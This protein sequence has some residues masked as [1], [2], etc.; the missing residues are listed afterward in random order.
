MTTWTVS[1]AAQLQSALNGA[2]GG[3]TIVLQDGNYGT[4]NLTQ[5]FNDYVTIQAAS[6]LG[7]IFNDLDITG[8]SY[9][10]LDGIKVNARPDIYDNANHLAFLNCA[11]LGVMMVQGGAHDVDL[12]G[13]DFHGEVLMAGYAPSSVYN[14]NVVGNVLHDTD[15]DMMN[16]TGDSYNIL[17]ENNS[18]LDMIAPDPAEHPDFIQMLQDFGSGKT[19]HDVVI[20]GNF[21]FDDPTTGVIG[22]EGIFISDAGPSGYKNILVEQ[23]I[24]APVLTNAITIQSGTENVVIQDNTVTYG[25]IWVVN[26]QGYGNA[27]TTVRDN[28]APYVVNDGG[29]AVVTHNYAYDPTPTKTLFPAYVNGSDWHQFVPAAGSAIDFGNGYGA[30]ARLEEL[31][32]GTTTSPGN[33][34]PHGTNDTVN[35]NEDTAAYHQRLD[36][37]RERHRRERRHAVDHGRWK[38]AARHCDPERQRF[39]HVYADRELQRPGHLHLHGLA[40]AKAAPA[41]PPLR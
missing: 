22:A 5:S 19:P 23:N 1:S 17:V 30:D 28:V 3:D 10:K 33:A 36:P 26:N 20:R 25:R 18:F 24:I 29:G 31:L 41:R 34:S 6:P 14:I 8:A 38:R 15:G 37:A 11:T 12:I 16:I 21:M 7:A 32:T 4:L 9:I 39:G 35:T 2:S 27:G 40:T 13:N